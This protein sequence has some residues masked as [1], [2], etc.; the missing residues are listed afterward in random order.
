MNANISRFLNMD[1][2]KFVYNIPYMNR[3][4]FY[5][6]EIMKKIVN[7]NSIKT[8]RFGLSRLEG[9]IVPLEI[10]QRRK[11]YYEKRIQNIKNGI[12]DIYYPIYQTI[13]SN[14]G[15]L[16]PEFIDRIIQEYESYDI[17]IREIFY[18]ISQNKNP[19]FLKN[20][21]ESLS[22]SYLDQLIIDYHFEDCYK[23][24]FLDLKN[25][26]DYI[27]DSNYS[28]PSKVYQKYQTLL[29]LSTMNISEKISIFNDL[30][31]E[32]NISEFYDNYR[33]AKNHCN[34]QIK[35]S[36]FGE[37]E[38]SKTCMQYRKNHVK[39][40]EL[41][42]EPF[43][44]FVKSF[45]ENR[46]NPM[47]NNFFITDREKV[48]SFSL[49]GSNSLSVFLNPKKYYTIMYGDFNPDQ[50]MYVTSYDSWSNCEMSTDLNNISDYVYELLSPEKIVNNHKEYSEIVYRQKTNEEPEDDEIAKNLLDPK[51][52]AIICFDRITFNDLISAK[53]F[54]LSIVLIHTNKYES[55]PVFEEPKKLKYEKKI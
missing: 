53:N 20:I 35:D 38:L 33:Q 22:L 8:Y 2:E 55:Y 50:I 30:K 7:L 14:L 44:A 25:L 51:P 10:E 23:N 52:I 3:E 21:F 17:N 47:S 32:D 40:Y 29:S 12:I 15:D 19:S 48:A 34:H 5:N 36:S 39:V 31:Q 6:K 41:N 49:I 24:F 11:K 16:T 37:L 45:Y 9:G 1:A 4:F 54:N 28:I 43:F 18:L 46:K 26:I 27:K 42:G 13:L